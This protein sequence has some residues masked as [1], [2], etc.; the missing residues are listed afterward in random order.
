VLCGEGPDSGYSAQHDGRPPDDSGTPRS[1]PSPAVRDAAS[2][3]KDVPP[4]PAKIQLLDSI[5]V[6]ARPDDTP[7][8]VEELL[9][10]IRICLAR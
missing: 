6:V 2:L 8:S 4:R 9:A 1:P 3:E 5:A 7:H 10:H